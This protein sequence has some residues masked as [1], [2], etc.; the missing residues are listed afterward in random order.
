[1]NENKSNE[2]TSINDEQANN[3]KKKNINSKRKIFYPIFILMVIMLL[4]II[5]FCNRYNNLVHKRPSNYNEENL[6]TIIEKKDNNSS[7]SNNEQQ[8]TINDAL[9]ST[10]NNSYSK[11]K[12]IDISEFDFEKLTT[13]INN[14]FINGNHAYITKCKRIN[15]ETLETS[16]ETIVLSHES[17]NTIVAKLKN[18]KSFDLSTASFFGCPPRG[19]EYTIGLKENKIFSIAYPYEGNYFLVGY[20]NNGYSFH[21]ESQ[22]DIDS[23]IENLK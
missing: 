18:A 6:N 14:S 20:N 3:D 16:T 2:N 15:H 21:Y 5:A 7:T 22:S 11:T 4:C 13:D 9:N 8:D 10:N 17:F 19:I 12:D 1:M 23:F